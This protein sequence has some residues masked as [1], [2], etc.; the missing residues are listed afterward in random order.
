[1]QWMLRSVQRIPPGNRFRGLMVG[2]S[3]PSRGVH[4]CPSGIVCRKRYEWDRRTAAANFG[5]YNHGA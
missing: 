3:D 4:K 1:M 5:G 2:S